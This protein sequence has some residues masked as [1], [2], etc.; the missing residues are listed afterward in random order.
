MQKIAQKPCQYIN[1]INNLFKITN[2]NIRIVTTI[3]VA[4]NQNKT[5]N[6]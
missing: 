1:T 5:D 2:Q 3:I 4:A 6:F